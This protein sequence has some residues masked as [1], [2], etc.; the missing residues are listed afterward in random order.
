M[1]VPSG[2]WLPYLHLR[3][4]E[5]SP[6]RQHLKGTDCVWVDHTVRVDRPFHLV[7][8]PSVLTLCP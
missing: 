5:Q 6:G 2:A 1:L 7:L 8:K 4:S 3:V